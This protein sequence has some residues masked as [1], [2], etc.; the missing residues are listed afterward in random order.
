MRKLRPLLL[1]LCLLLAGCGKNAA[2]ERFAPF[3]EALCARSDLCFSAEVRA[4]YPDRSA[5]F[6]LSYADDAPGCRVTVLEPA[7]IRGVTV[8]LDGA[9]ASLGYDSVVLDTG[10]LDR[11]GL[12]P[13]S[14]LAK[15]V[16]ALRTGHLASA[17]EEDGLT[18]WEL[19]PDDT[20][21][22]QIWLTEDMIPVRA[23]L[24]S[25]GR[26]AVYCEFRDWK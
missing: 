24:I 13:A 5:R 26:A 3:S 12:S 25:E 1:T 18:V 2:A 7:E 20:L 14:A 23:E 22:V 6:L 16:S 9:S 4:E 15:L 21:T 19:V 10:A 8:H 17:W 11:Y